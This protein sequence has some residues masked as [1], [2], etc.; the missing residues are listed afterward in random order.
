MQS[1][2]M[3]DATTGARIDEQ[4]RESAE[5]GRLFESALEEDL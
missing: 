3:T 2:S 4:M 5:D 1:A